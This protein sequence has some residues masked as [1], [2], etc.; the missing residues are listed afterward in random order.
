MTGFF[1]LGLP[2]NPPDNV[3]TIKLAKLID[4]IFLN[5]VTRS[6]NILGISENQLIICK[7]NTGLIPKI[8]QAS[9]VTLGSYS[10]FLKFLHQGR[11][12]SLRGVEAIVPEGSTK[13]SL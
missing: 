6:V 9:L 8:N 2:A 10:G 4:I 7:K 13:E 3:D 12:D 11:S 5:I 1:I